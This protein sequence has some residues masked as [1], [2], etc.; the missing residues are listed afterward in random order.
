MTIYEYAV[1]ITDEFTIN[2]PD[3][4]NILSVGVQHEDPRLWAMVDPSRASVPHRFRLVGTGHPVNPD[5]SWR[6]IGT[7]QLHGGALVSHLFL[8][9]VDSEVT[10]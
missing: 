4:A 8:V 3:G 6:F 10:P 5:D 7:F 2:I 9:C 1:S